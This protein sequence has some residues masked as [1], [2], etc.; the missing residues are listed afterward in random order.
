MPVT[1]YPLPLRLPPPLPLARYPSHLPLPFTFVC[2]VPLPV[3]CYLCTFLPLPPP[4]RLL[5]YPL[6]R[7]PCV[8]CVPCVPYLHVYLTRF[9]LPLSV[10]FTSTFSPFTLYLFTFTVTRH[11]LP[12]T[13]TCTR[14]LYLLPLPLPLLLPLPL[15]SFST[16]H[17]LPFTL[18]SHSSSES[19]LTS[20]LNW[21]YPVTLLRVFNPWPYPWRFPWHSWLCTWPC[22]W[23]R[24]WPWPP[25]F[26]PTLAPWPYPHTVPCLGLIHIDVV[27]LRF[28]ATPQIARKQKLMLRFESN[29]HWLCRTRLG[30]SNISPKKRMKSP[31]LTKES[32]KSSDLTKKDL[33]REK[34]MNQR[35]T[36]SLSSCNAYHSHWRSIKSCQIQIPVQ[37]TSF[38]WETSVSHRSWYEPKT[39]NKYEHV[40]TSPHWCWRTS[41]N[42][43]FH[44]SYLT[45]V[46]VMIIIK[47]D[48]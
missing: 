5:V 13:F 25:N 46:R 3:T 31:L 2:A 16:L 10:T 7:I 41:T 12:V 30:L 9:P 19:R 23:F 44:V 4:V 29:P 39:E 22:T 38:S 24:P 40:L 14:H 33:S 45:R 28:A 42:K 37:V 8:P 34:E 43:H 26:T 48:G 1:R 21:H 35:W 18:H 6:T 15:S 11:P 17:P 32:S 20:N 47:L 36:F 27:L